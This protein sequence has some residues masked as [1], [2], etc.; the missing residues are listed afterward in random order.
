MMDEYIGI[1]FVAEGRS[2]DGCDC[3]GLIRLIYRDHK[4]IVLPTYTGY[5]D[6]LAR[7][8]TDLIE[9]GRVDWE[10]VTQPQPYDA[11]LFLVRGQ[12]HHIG[13]V[14][15]PGW[16]IHTA[17]GKQSCIES[18]NRPLWRSRIEGFYR[19]R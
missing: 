9:A 2:R 12:P 7:A 6:P 17:R 8:A 16:M 10:K 1:P 18:Y 19:V 11:V 5:G 14:I 15:R 3:W 4:G 13:L